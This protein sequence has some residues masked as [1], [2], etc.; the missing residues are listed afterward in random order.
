M[1]VVVRPMR[2]DEARLFLE[3]HGR[4]IRGLAA[5]HYSAD[6]IDAWAAPVTD[7][8]V[9][10]F[11]MNPDNEIRL[12]AEIDGQPVGLGALVVDNAELR[13][14]YVV[15]EAARKGVGLA[16]VKEMERIAREH[17]LTHLHLHASVNA[18]P[19]YVALGYEA[20]EREEH[21]LRSGYRMVSL[22][23]RKTLIP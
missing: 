7:E 12:L 3:I 9:Q 1:S 5:A 21:S 14:C 2:D 23:M 4:S 8:S 10:G 16:L 19:F 11:L 17:G 6:V 18:E 15:P 13:A 20:L 22:K